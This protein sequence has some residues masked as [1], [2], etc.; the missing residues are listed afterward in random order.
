M[1]MIHTVNDYEV[2]ASAVFCCILPCRFKTNKIT[3]NTNILRLSKVINTERM[4]PTMC[5]LHIFISF[6]GNSYILVT[7]ASK[8]IFLYLHYLI[9][10]K[11]IVFIHCYILPDIALQWFSNIRVL[12]LTTQHICKHLHLLTTLKYPTQNKGL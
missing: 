8:V 4:L 7:Q 11:V 10:L 9:S 2:C 5:S 3:Y 1:H 6:P 12:K